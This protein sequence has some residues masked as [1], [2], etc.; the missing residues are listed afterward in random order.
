MFEGFSLP[1]HWFVGG[2]YVVGAELLFDDRLSPGSYDLVFLP[3]VLFFVLRARALR[4]PEFELLRAVP[5]A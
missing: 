1:A 5:D 2:S 4:R 3:P